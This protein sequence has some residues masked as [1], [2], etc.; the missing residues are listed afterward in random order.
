MLNNL[1]KSLRKNLRE[2]MWEISV[3]VSTFLEIIKYYILIMCKSLD[4]HSFLNINNRN[5]STS[6]FINSSLLNSRF[7]QFPHSLLLLLLN[8]FNII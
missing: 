5:F 3:N 4:I 2:S 8:K 6:K 7:S 1:C